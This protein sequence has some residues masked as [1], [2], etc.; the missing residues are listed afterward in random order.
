MRVSE[1]E[2]RR[3]EK[4]CREDRGLTGSCGGAFPEGVMWERGLQG[5]E[6]SGRRVRLEWKR[7]FHSERTL[8]SG[9]SKWRGA[10]K[11]PRRP[12]WLMLM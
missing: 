1:A 5:E 8:W 6:E 3:L 10:Q 2:L 7:E 9:A 11:V 12:V 4:V